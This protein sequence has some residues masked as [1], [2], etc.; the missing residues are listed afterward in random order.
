MDRSPPA[1]SVLGILQER[2]LEWVAMPFSRGSAWPRDWTQVCCIA[3]RFFIIWAPRNYTSV[4]EKREKFKPAFTW[5]K[6]FIT[7]SL[8]SKV[9]LYLQGIWAPWLPAARPIQLAHHTLQQ[10]W[11]E[12]HCLQ[13]SQA[14]RGKRNQFP[15]VKSV[16]SKMPRFLSSFS[17]YLFLVIF[18]LFPDGLQDTVFRF[19]NSFL[20][21]WTSPSS[22]PNLSIII[23]TKL[24]PLDCKFTFRLL[25]F[26]LY[27]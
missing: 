20:F 12:I 6:D 23:F 10:A 16:A 5:F 13:P 26:F 27:K 24:W 7:W 17:L 22:F 15:L 1:S 25:I 2:I 3:G 8:P 18:R 4:K 19:S 9:L 14:P 21:L 11:W